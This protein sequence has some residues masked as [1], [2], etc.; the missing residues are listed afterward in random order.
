MKKT[1]K[2]TAA[3]LGVLLLG[4]VAA[5]LWRQ[6]YDRKAPNFTERFELFVHPWMEPESVLDSLLST[7]KVRNVRSLQ[8]AFRSQGAAE[9]VKVGHYTVDPS[10]SS[11]YVARMLRKGWQTPVRLTLAGSIRTKGVLA[12]KIGAQM[13]V[14]S[15][16]V[17][18]F[19]LSPDSLARFGTDTVRL[20]CMV[21]PDTYQVYWTA[22]VSEIFALF[23][24]AH[25]AYW[26]EE[27]VRKAS[28]QGLTPEEVSIL[29]S[30][31]DGESHYGPEQPTIAGVYLNRLR[32]GMLLQADPTVAYC[33]GYRLSRILTRHLEVDSP[34]NTYKYA[35]LP[36]GP[37]S[38]HRNPALMRS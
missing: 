34:Y 13:Q 27:R 17:A 1:V 31:V 38:C 29:A 10:S 3:A 4:M 11:V 37:I 28:A 18:A 21:I 36:P 8:R 19:A 15:A 23:K 9:E 14:D 6:Y 26:T 12:R 35:G 22:S 2:W 16:D 30:I 5:E 24:N 33:F 20:F 25:D 7:G 32:S